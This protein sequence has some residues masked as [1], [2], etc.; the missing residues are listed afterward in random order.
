MFGN[1]IGNELFYSYFIV[2]ILRGESFIFRL[3][4]SRSPFYFAI[5]YDDT[6]YHDGIK[7]FAVLFG[8]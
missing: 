7:L 3:S 5:Y 1:K 8:I 6:Y 4:E 2:N